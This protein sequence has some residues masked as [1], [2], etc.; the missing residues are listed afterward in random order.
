MFQI[1]SALTTFLSF[2]VYRFLFIS[3]ALFVEEKASQ[4]LGLMA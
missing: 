2:A 4:N 3:K 1:G